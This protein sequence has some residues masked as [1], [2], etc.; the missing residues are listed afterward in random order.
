M[1]ILRH[2][3]WTMPASVYGRLLVEEQIVDVSTTVA[4][5]SAIWTGVGHKL[6]EHKLRLGLRW[7]QEASVVHPD[8]DALAWRVSQVEHTASPVLERAMRVSIQSAIELFRRD[9]PPVNWD[10]EFHQ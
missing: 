7:Q 5:H 8:G 6:V 2:F 1:V 9:F 3:L 10:L 4:N